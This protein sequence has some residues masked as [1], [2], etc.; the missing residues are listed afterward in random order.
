MFEVT[1]SAGGG[2]DGGH[3]ETSVKLCHEPVESKFISAQSEQRYSSND[4][5][6]TRHGTLMAKS[7]LL[8]R[9]LKLEK[10]DAVN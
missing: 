1:Q 8:S 9:I 3:I 7:K 6:S 4:F 5:T 10:L 2:G